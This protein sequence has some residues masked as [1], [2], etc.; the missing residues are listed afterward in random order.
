M[1]PEVQSPPRL[2]LG[3]VLLFWGAMSGNPLLGL[4][5]ALLIEGANWIKLRWDFRSTAC[6]R[7]WR[8]SMLLTVI[9]GTLIWLDGDR[10]TAVP[11]LFTWLPILL[12]PLQFVQSYGL[13]NWM[14]LNSFSFFTKLHRQRNQ[15]LNHA[16]SVIHFNFGNVYF[17]VAIMAA[18]LGRYADQ[19]IFFPCIILL[20]G[21][22]I[23]SRLSIRPFALVLVVVMA[24]ILGFSGQLGM[25]KLYH[26]ATNRS[27]EGGYPSTDP[28]A[29]K[30]AI[31]SLGKL[32]QS[33]EMLWRLTPAPGTSPPKL[34]RLATYN[35]YKGIVWRNDFPDPLVEDE[36]SFRDLT[37]I[38]LPNGE[39]RFLLRENMT[40]AEISRPLPSFKIRGASSSEAPLPLPA[41]SSS[42][43][44]FELDGIE[45]NPV[46][47]VR[48]FPRKSIIEGAIRWKDDSSPD[49]EPWLKEDLAI[50]SIEREGIQRIVAELGLKNLPTTKEKI[51]RLRK[52]FV[53]EFSYTRY[54]TIGPARA[55][56]PSAIE[57]FLTTGKRGHCE[58]FA[59]AST[60]LLR[61]A[62][63]PARYCVGY[64]VLEKDPKHNDFV[65]RGIHGHAWTRYWDEQ[66]GEWIDYDSTPAQWLPMELGDEEESRWFADSFQRFREDFFLWRNRPANRLG[67]TIVMWS[68]G[69]S[70]F[71]FIAYRLWRSRIKS[72]SP[73]RKHYTTGPVPITP[74]HSLE[75]PASKILGPRPQGEPLASWLE[76]LSTLNIAALPEALDIHQRLRFDPTPGSDHLLI[77]LQALTKEIS[78]QIRKR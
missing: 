43:R 20:A 69:L 52:F 60:L 6:S 77:R 32:K 61:A 22:L 27:L 15:R 63:V 62:G 9:T 28:T 30:T 12:F 41:T 33:P 17:V 59:T 11:K 39:S 25:K 67:A 38:P 73:A 4:I 44:D 8:I 31:G 3:A 35:R 58:Y 66:S 37:A 64:A 45:I 13:R 5:A 42:L 21:W 55:T 72:T 78:A 54:L 75:R 68:I 34:L 50:S 36:T 23:F 56:R 49:A 24:S 76:K 48:V 2:L 19:T 10:Y 51:A 53:S 16:D 70:V 14:A 1:H 47:T 71:V 29:N 26:W 40:P 57:K 46:G 7:A 74:L 65:I 18:G